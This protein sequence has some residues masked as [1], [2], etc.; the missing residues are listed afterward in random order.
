MNWPN[1]WQCKNPHHKIYPSSYSEKLIK[2]CWYCWGGGLYPY[3]PIRASILSEIFTTGLQPRAILFILRDLVC[4][5]TNTWLPEKQISPVFIICI[6]IGR[7][8]SVVL[9][10]TILFLRTNQL[11]KL[12][13]VI[14]WFVYHCIYL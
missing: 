5:Y 2:L 14:I 3:R 9:I 7:I 6:N 12:L 10:L 8:Y 4:Y 13:F 11:G 1:W